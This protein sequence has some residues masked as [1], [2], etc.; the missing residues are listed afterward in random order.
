[1]RAAVLH[2]GGVPA[3]FQFDLDCAPTCYAIANSFDRRFARNSPGRVLCYRSFET[4]AERGIARIDWG[5][6][7]PGYKRT[8]GAEPGPEI[9]DYLFVRG[10]AGAAIARAFWR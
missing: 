6:G 2:I 5:A 4:L 7:D 1:M 10:A 9:V 8:M 3:A